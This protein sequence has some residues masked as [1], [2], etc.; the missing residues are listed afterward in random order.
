MRSQLHVGNQI[1]VLPPRPTGAIYVREH[2]NHWGGS[3]SVQGSSA[4]NGDGGAVLES[5]SGVGNGSGCLW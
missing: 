3:I 5:F 2:F 4:K 1:I